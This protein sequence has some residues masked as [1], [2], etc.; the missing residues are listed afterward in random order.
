MFA[1]GSKILVVDDMSM[2]RIFIISCLNNFGYTN[3]NEAKDGS[4]A[5]QMLLAANPKY[6]L[7]I[8]DWSMPIISG[9]DL[10]KKIRAEDR[11][12]KTPVIMITSES[13]AEL[14][15]EALKAGVTNYVIK[16]FTKEILQNKLQIAYEKCK[17]S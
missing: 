11:L 15:T 17:A 2:V 13:D 3:I 6:D 7:I 14:V 4:E 16:P 1:V 10:L 5:W 8:S 9:I 12:K